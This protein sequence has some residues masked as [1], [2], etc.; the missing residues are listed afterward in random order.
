MR[1]EFSSASTAG[2]RVCRRFAIAGRLDMAA[3]LAFVEERGRWFGID[4]WVAAEDAR[5]VTLVAAGPDAMV[6]ALEMACTLG[7][8]SALVE[9]ID[10]IEEPQPAKA[11]F[12]LVQK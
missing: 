8:L 5:R 7:P 11:G 2:Q 3:Y 1:A 6:G 4:G 12:A 9:E 10:A